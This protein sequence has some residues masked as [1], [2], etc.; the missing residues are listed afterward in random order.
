MCFKLKSQRTQCFI[1][2]SS[3]FQSETFG[4]VSA[5]LKLL[6]TSEQRICDFSLFFPQLSITGGKTEII[7]EMHI[8]KILILIRL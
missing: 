2:K 4:F 3:V 8:D 1:L 6:V 7:K 5:G